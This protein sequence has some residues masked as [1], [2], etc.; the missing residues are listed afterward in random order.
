MSAA[1][2]AAGH[3]LVQAGRPCRAC[4]VEL[5]VGRVTQADPNLLGDDV[6]A[7]VELVAVQGATL[8][9]LAR[10]LA[11]SPGALLVGAPATVGRLVVEL[12][13]RGSALP[14][15][16]CARCRRTGF[17]LIVSSEGGVCPRCRNRQL[18]CPCAI[19]GVVK[20]IAGRDRQGRALC[21]VCAPRPK[22][23]CSRCGN[24]RIVARR[25]AENH[26]DLCDS[27]YKGPVAVCGVCGRERPCNFAAVRPVC[28]SCSPRRCS[29]CAHCGKDR[30]PCARWPEGP[31]C[32]SCYRAALTRRG[33]CTGCSAE[34]RLI[35]P[36]GPDA[37]R[38]AD[39]AGV[40]GLARC[41]ACGAEDR[42]YRHG[43]CVRCAL[44]ERARE[45][46]GDG[47]GPLTAVHDAIVVAPQ[48][49][50]AHNW[51]RSGVSAAVLADVARGALPLTHE[52]LDAHPHTRAANYLRH[53]L[54]AHGVLPARDD[55]IV[56]LE[57]WVAGRL[58]NLS[59]LGHR[60][61]LRSYATWR[62]LRRARQ[63]AQ[64]ARRPPTPTARAKACLNAAI[65]FLAFLDEHSK[66]LASC[67]QT[68]IDT[69]L[70]D[71]PP[72][73]T[74]I[75][76]FI[77]WATNR[78]LTAPVVIP[79]RHRRDGPAL[80][81]NT[82]W[83]IVHRLLHDDTLELGDRVAGCLV[84]LY[85]QQISRIVAI[86]RDQISHHDGTLRVHLGATHIE[87]PEPLATLLTRLANE[88]RP[89]TTVVPTPTRQWLFPGLDPGQPLNAS[90]LGQRL[91]RIDIPTMA[92]RRTA[93]IHLAGR[94]PAAVLADLLGIAP[95]TAVHWVRTAGG[96]WTTYAAQ[97]IRDREL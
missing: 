16:V 92:G 72:S 54:V 65:A 18:A 85:G 70:T 25:A 51:L 27:C 22:R 4:R 90:H 91:R 80:D 69:W 43:L 48:P 39:C 12:R 89:K 82:R 53:I 30:P 32:E 77:D 81:D 35:H 66:D 79:A 58:A 29:R 50:S 64:T 17:E 41:A 73:A 46:I 11:D 34:R 60:R 95:T 23:P 71:G 28:V 56:R 78:K 57:A 19:C 62:V 83:G 26:G 45:V 14:E 20:P 84:L 42:P 5:V 13:A 40:A 36:P 88:R 49:Y 61:L 21:A 55:A 38:C 63:R 33:V 74:E 67:T 97:L 9:D 7:A 96:D 10:A 59:S 52:A 76:D 15:P 44:A 31:V 75:S 93:L 1:R 2:C 8:R 86:T 37:S 47:D 87:I 94:L 6:R 3:E 24:V 68:D